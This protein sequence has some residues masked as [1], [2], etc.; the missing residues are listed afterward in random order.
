[1]YMA[2][3]MLGALGS[4]D[5]RTDVYLLGAVLHEI[6]TGTPPHQGTFRQIV[7]SI[8]MS[9]PKYGPDV[10]RELA[11]IARR[12]MSREPAAR[13]ASVLEMRQRLEWYLRH[14]GSLALS[15]EAEKSLAVMQDLIVEGTLDE[16]TRDRIYHLFVEARF[17]FRQAIAASADNHGAQRGLR[18][19]IEAVVGFELAAGT[20]EAASS[21]LA[22]LEDPQPTL[23]AR[24]AAAQRAAKRHRAELERVRADHDPQTGRRTRLA[25]GVFAGISWTIAPLLG[26]WLETRVD[27]SSPHAVRIM[28][29]WTAV[30]LV[31][32]L[33]FGA[34]GRESLSKT[35]VNR[36]ARA[37]ATINFA[38]QF[39]IELA[40]DLAHVP[41]TTMMILHFVVWFMAASASMVTIDTR[42]WPAPAIYL[43]G[44]VASSIVPGLFWYI[45]ALTNLGLVITLVVAWGSLEDAMKR[46][47]QIAGVVRRVS[48]RPPPNADGS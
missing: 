33:G 30:M 24:V 18:S 41:W 29:V 36:R 13:F 27:T 3:E 37:I 15:R 32:G 14:R 42:L 7:G 9:D 23:V 44:L 26:P 31:I 25:V 45:C 43:L 11:E 6:L 46:R 17:G 35:L 20:A 28:Y 16:D 38:G 39:M 34:W 8:L 10:P 12:A 4:L 5:E 19:A 2:P 48:R 40:C 1:A 47:E 21:A 22:E